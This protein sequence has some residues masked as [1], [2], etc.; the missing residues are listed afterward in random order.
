[1]TLVEPIALVDPWVYIRQALVRQLR[2]NLVL[3]DELPGNWSEGVAPKDTPFPRGIYQLHYSPN[4]YDWTGVVTVTGVDVGV[5]SKTQGE[6]ASL[7]QLVFTT[8]QDARLD[9]TG[10]SML[11]CRRVSTY[12]LVDAAPDGTETVFQEGGIYSIQVAQSNPVNRT[13]DVTVTSTIG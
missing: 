10:L 11:V 5:F 7:N 3:E 9:V 1:M 8:L 12:S 4:E 2:S 13:L 6:A